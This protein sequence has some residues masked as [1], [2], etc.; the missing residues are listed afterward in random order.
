[1]KLQVDQLHEEAL[2]GLVLA[3]F[4]LAGLDEGVR[5]Q[6]RRDLTGGGQG[7]PDDGGL[8]GVGGVV[9]GG[10]GVVAAAAAAAWH[11]QTVG[12]EQLVFSARERRAA[13]G[14]EE[15]G[16]GRAGGHT[17]RIPGILAGFMAGGS[18]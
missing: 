15:Q 17:L 16:Q 13:G 1:M 6:A 12:A 7:G 8:A 5:G 11:T 14:E 2:A 10:V 18:S 9:V 3:S 4:V